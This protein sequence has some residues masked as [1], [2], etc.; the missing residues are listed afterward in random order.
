MGQRVISFT[1]SAIFLRKR[2]RIRDEMITMFNRLDEARKRKFRSKSLFYGLLWILGLAYLTVVYIIGFYSYFTDQMTTF[3]G[4]KNRVVIL[5]FGVW[6]AVDTLSFM[7]CWMSSNLLFLSYVYELYDKYEKVIVESVSQLKSQQEVESSLQESDHRQLNQ[8]A[9]LRQVYVTF[10][11]LRKE[12]SFIFREISVFSLFWFIQAFLGTIFRLASLV[13]HEREDHEYMIHVLGFY[14]FA[15]AYIMMTTLIADKTRTAQKRRYERE[16]E[17]FFALENPE[18]S[19]VKTLI[20]KE[21][22]RL[23]LI[24]PKVWKIFDLN[25]KL[26]FHFYG[27]VIPFTV[28]CRDLFFEK[29]HT[30]E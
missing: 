25:T 24:R 16:A 5:C 8:L 6:K 20:V 29:Y 28:Y 27:H 3:L 2:I 7:A 4:L 9:Q 30:S 17:R 23:A 19:H 15:M 18:F 21:L 11:N 22:D 12:K 26:L 1:T 13:A 10:Q 14:F